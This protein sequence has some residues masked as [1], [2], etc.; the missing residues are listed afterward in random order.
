MIGIQTPDKKTVKFKKNDYCT[1]DDVINKFN[2]PYN[3]F[4]VY[5]FDC[6]NKESFRN[7]AC[8]MIRNKEKLMKHKNNCRS[9]VVSMVVCCFCD[10]V[11]IFVIFI[12]HQCLLLYQHFFWF[13][14]CTIGLYTA[15]QIVDE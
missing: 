3:K 7:D 2:K 11:C 5:N 4:Q 6:T 15:C 10:Q 13:V 9:Q 14:Y 12:L 8:D 1:C